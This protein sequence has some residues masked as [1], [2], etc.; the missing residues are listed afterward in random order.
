MATTAQDI[1]NNITNLNKRIQTEGITDNAGNVLLSPNISIDTLKDNNQ[2]M[3]FPTQTDDTNYNGIINAGNVM[4]TPTEDNSDPTFKAYLEGIKNIE[5]NRPSTEGIYNAEYASAGIDQRNQDVIK[6]QGELDA[7]NAQLQG[8]SAEGQQ[9]NLALEQGAS[10]KD[11]TTQFLGRQQQEV[12]RQTAIKS[13]PLQAQALV[14]QAK[15][16]N[17]ISLL[18][19]AKDKLNTLFQIRSKDAENQYN[20]KTNIINKMYEFMTAKQKEQADA[21]KTKQANEFTLMRDN[22]NNAQEIATSILE[23]QP[24]LS[25]KM[26]QIDW[27]SPTAKAD[28]AKL[29]SQI[30]PDPMRA[31]DIAVKQAQLAKI[32]KETKLLGEPTPAEVKATTE[33]IKNAKTSLPAMQDKVSAIDV[34]KNSAGLNSRVGVNIFTRK[35]TDIV[36]GILKYGSTGLIG[37]IGDIK[38]SFGAGQAFAGGVHKLV[39]GLSLDALIQAKER[40]ATFGALSDSELNILANSASAINDWEIKKDGKPTGVWNIDEATF[41]K[42]LDNIKNLTSRAILLSQGTLMSSEEQSLLD[43]LYINQ[44]ASAFYK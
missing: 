21:L 9:A 18:N 39:S 6:A 3:T 11:V 32:Q 36:G 12:S 20:Y 30:K 16:S 37:G 2:K 19:S 41:K 22:I 33:A 17:N 40:G 1:Q 25:A 27:S 42:E 5:A 14:A 8:I 43:D 31:L 44:D 26:S 29:Q 4:S 28:F 13:L 10:G 34:L 15:V 24:E 23:S 7:I 35:P 38:D